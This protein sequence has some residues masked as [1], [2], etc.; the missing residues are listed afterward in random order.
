MFKLR[1]FFELIKITLVSIFIAILFRKKNRPF[2]YKYL[3]L[4]Q[5]MITDEEFEAWAFSDA[6]K[7]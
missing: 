2:V 4:K 1:D 5:G 3:E 6:M 7:L